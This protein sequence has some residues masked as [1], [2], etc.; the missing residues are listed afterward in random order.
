MDIEAKLY[1]WL[2]KHYGV[3]NY[4]PGFDR[5]IPYIG[6]IKQSLKDRGVKII[7]IGGTN[8]K[9]ETSHVLSDL[10]LKNGVNHGLWISPHINTIRERISYNG[11]MIDGEELLNIFNRVQLIAEDSS[12][13][14]LSYFEFLFVVFLN[15]VATKPLDCLVLEVGLGGRL[16][17]TNF[18]DADIA[19]I[20][21]IARDHQ[22]YLGKTLSSILA[23]KLEISRRDKPLV[24]ALELQFCRRQVE[25]FSIE[26]HLPHLDLFSS[27]VIDSS[28]NFSFRNIM[29]AKTLFEI[30]QSGDYSLDKF[31][32]VKLDRTV[33]YFSMRGRLERIDFHS[34]Q[35]YFTGSHNVDGIRKLI[36][37]MD[38]SIGDFLGANSFDYLL[39]SLTNRPKSDV[40]SILK[41]IAGASKYFK[42]IYLTQFEAPKAMKW[43]R[44]WLSDFIDKFKL[45]F[46]FADDWQDFLKEKRVESATMLVTGS[47]YLIGD[48]QN[49]LIS[50]GD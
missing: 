26:R 9:G 41:I 10:L 50:E 3:E 4:H 16:D 49:H 46:F 13:L 30:Y 39:L 14:P 5:L 33:R 15:Y 34:L 35:L 28:D 48:I 32:P 25:S 43:D 11:E 36:H 42:K 18:L 12:I 20:C 24:T 21:S 37:F 45:P 40:E 1:N 23:E 47:N 31:N 27:G 2:D 19:A 22:A 6:E 17:A 44:V 8:G 38:S 7:T 29:L